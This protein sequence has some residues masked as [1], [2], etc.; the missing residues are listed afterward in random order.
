M[1]KEYNEI[2]EQESTA[3]MVNDDSMVMCTADVLRQQCVEALM[4]ISDINILGDIK[5]QLLSFLN[6]KCC[7]KQHSYSIEE[8]SSRQHEAMEEFKAGGGM[9][10]ELFFEKMTQYI[11]KR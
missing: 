3:S 1:P 11:T 7:Q 10:G 8:L 2:F 6:N 9:D 5:Q 4:D